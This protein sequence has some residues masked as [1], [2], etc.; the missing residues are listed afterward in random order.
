VGTSLPVIEGNLRSKLLY[1]LLLKMFNFNVLISEIKQE[2]D[3]SG[4]KCASGR[5]RIKSSRILRPGDL[6]SPSDISN[7]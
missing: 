2:D 7:M 5:E 6:F 4:G 3:C 1:K